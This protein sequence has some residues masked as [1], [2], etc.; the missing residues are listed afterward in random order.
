MTLNMIEKLL[1]FK[2][3]YDMNS[4]ALA[5]ELGI[6]PVYL[7]QVLKG[8]RKLSDKMINR[9]EI[10]FVRFNFCNEGGSYCD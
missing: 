3:K 9:V 10:L 4:I 5:Q 8:R 1:I 6:S 2:Y 7:C